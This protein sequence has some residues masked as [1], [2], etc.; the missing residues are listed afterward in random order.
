[1]TK[2]LQEAVLRAESLPPNKQ[3]ALALVMQAEMGAVAGLEKVRP[4]PGGALD[5]LFQQVRREFKAGLNDP[6]AAEEV[7][8]K[9]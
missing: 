7:P 8:P 9:N 1:M 3:D 4:K 6:P 5:G 2:L